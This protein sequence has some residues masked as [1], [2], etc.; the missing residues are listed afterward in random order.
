[1]IIA[2]T[3]DCRA[4]AMFEFE[5]YLI[6][7]AKRLSNQCGKPS[8]VILAMAFLLLWTIVALFADIPLVVHLIVDILLSIT[9]MLMVILLQNAHKRDIRAL[10]ARIEELSEGREIDRTSPDTLT[11]VEVP[12]V[13]D[14]LQHCGESDTAR[15]ARRDWRPS[16][17]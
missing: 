11:D 1:M 9:T 16:L 2:H 5:S 15:R 8:A 17:F 14:L 6:E 7:L 13:R 10:Q 4:N 3:D 12:Q